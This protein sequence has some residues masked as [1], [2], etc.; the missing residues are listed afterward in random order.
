MTKYARCTSCGGIYPEEMVKEIQFSYAV[1]NSSSKDRLI[2]TDAYGML[3]PN[4]AQ[5]KTT[6]TSENKSAASKSKSY[7]SRNT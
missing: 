1:F 5:R 4:C 6:T 7:S 2:T 3:C